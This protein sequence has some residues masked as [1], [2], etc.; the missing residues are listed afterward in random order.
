MSKFEKWKISWENAEGKKQAF[1]WFP[2]GDHPD[3]HIRAL[4]NLAE[5]DADDAGYKVEYEVVE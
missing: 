1:A 4:T 5:L 3:E 2:T